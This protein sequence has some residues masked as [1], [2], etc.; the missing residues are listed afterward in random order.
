MTFSNFESLAISVIKLH[1]C[2]VVIIGV[3]LFLGLAKGAFSCALMEMH[4]LL[5]LRVLGKF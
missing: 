4:E 2:G 5:D 3:V 1:F